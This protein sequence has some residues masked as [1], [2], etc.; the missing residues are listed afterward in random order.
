MVRPLPA[1]PSYEKQ[2]AAEQP[3]WTAGLGARPTNAQSAADWDELAGLAAAYRETYNVAEEQPGS[4]LGPVPGTS[5]AKAHA[6]DTITERWSPPVTTSA[7][8]MR[9]MSA[10]TLLLDLRRGPH[11]RIA[12]LQAT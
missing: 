11:W 6:W 10:Q 8:P 7:I 2:V 3:S 4:P 9:P 5:G 1:S 12:L